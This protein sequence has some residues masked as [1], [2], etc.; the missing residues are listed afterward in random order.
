MVA[1]IVAGGKGTRLGL[2]NIPK[3]MI[4]IDDVPLLEHQINVLK[5]YGIKDF[6]ILTGYLSD[7]IINH[8][9]DG[10]NFGV[11]IFYRTEQIPLGTAGCLKQLER[12]IKNRFLLVY[13]DIMFDMDIGKLI[14]ID[15]PDSIATVVVHPNDHPY[16]SDLVEIDE[17][18]KITHFHLKPHDQNIY[19]DNL[20][21]S[22]IYILSPEIFNYIKPNESQDLIKD[23]LSK[24]INIRSYLSAEYIK[25]IGTP[26]RLQQVR[27]DY[28]YGKIGKL[29]SKNKR[30]AI[31]IDRDGVIN[32]SKGDLSNINDFELLPNVG[33][34]IKKINESGYLAIVATN[35]PCMAKG[36]LTINGLTKIHNKMK[37]LLGQEKA[38]VDAIYYCPHH[39]DGGFKGE[40]PELKINCS[41]RKPKPGML[42]DAQIDFNIDLENSWMIGDNYN[43]ILAGET[44]GCKTCLVGNNLKEYYWF[45]ICAEN[46]D[47]A[48][49]R[50]LYDNK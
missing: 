5:R 24:L 12:Y 37:W 6:Y 38:F 29:N 46:L 17:T 42:Y 19:Y 27:K 13:G 34:A 48:V 49:N 44:A 10:G 39:P 32:K 16:D 21:N 40:I 2:T 47:K 30:F 14:S 15:I 36:F 18:G 8:F 43:D 23:I 7:C 26:E 1:V 9:G 28:K 33:K 31:F 45:D 11:N 25:D 50:I 22:G 35:Q 41:C 20:V 3:P 4:T